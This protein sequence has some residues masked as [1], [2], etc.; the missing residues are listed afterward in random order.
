MSLEKVE[1]F[2]N[3]QKD[4]S[5]GGVVNVDKRSYENYIATRNILRQKNAQQESTEETVASLSSEI[6]NIKDDIK[7]I[8][9]LL[10]SLLN[11]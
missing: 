7:D 1:G 4:T 11:K 8:K 10:M 9:T 5:N 3:L 2:T 6:N